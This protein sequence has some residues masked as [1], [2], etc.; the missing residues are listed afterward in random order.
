MHI[1]LIN[2][3]FV[4]TG[5]SGGTRHAEIGRLLTDNG[6]DFTVITS[7]VSYLTGAGKGLQ[8]D[9]VDLPARM[10]I[11][12]AATAAG[13]P[14]GFLS[15]LLAFFTFML[16]SLFHGL[17]VPRPDIVWGTSPNLFQALT[18]WLVA[19]CRG[20]KFV[21]EIRDLWPDFAI[22]MGVLK[23]RWIIAASRWLEK[24]LCRHADEIVVN[25]PGFIPHIQ[26]LCSR[27][28]ILIANG[29]DV[30]LF[31]SDDGGKTFRARH[32]LNGCF[33][34]MYTGA[35]GHANDLDTVLDAAE[36]MKEQADVRFVLVGSGKEK[37]RLLEQAAARYLENVLFIPPVPKNQMADVL[38]AADTGLAILKAIPLLLRPTRTKSLI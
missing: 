18:A 12:Y 28:P 19:R 22:G 35:H 10:K 2:Q 13:L 11:R 37:K 38:A 24:F 4:T 31:K 8:P 5:E 32:H 1:L 6:H 29:S 20:T 36:M 25:S 30:D 9:P 16:S 21:L 34:V 26:E 27:T 14:Q 3:A 15:R 33:V 7:P 17:R 23:N